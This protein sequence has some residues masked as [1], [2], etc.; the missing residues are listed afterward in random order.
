MLRK[1]ELD[2]SHVISHKPIVFEEDL[3]FSEEAIQIM[4]RKEQARRNKNIPLVKML[5][6]YHTLED[7]TW[8]WEADIQEKYPHLFLW[9]MSFDILSNLED[10]IS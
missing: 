3:T 4:D 8:A 9:G 1:Y 5:W 10:Q 7:D 2:P 6:K